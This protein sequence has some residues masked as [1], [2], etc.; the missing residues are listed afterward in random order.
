MLLALRRDGAEVVDEIVYIG[1]M[2]SVGAKGTFVRSIGGVL[3]LGY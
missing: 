1:S 3:V 2:R